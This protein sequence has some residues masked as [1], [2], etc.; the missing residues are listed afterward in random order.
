M[1]SYEG[2]HVSSTVPQTGPRLIRLSLGRK[3]GKRGYKKN[4]NN[5]KESLT[6][7]VQYTVSDKHPNV[8]PGKAFYIKIHQ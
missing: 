3:V 8:L 7:R 2:L 5:N 1:L 4:M 6:T